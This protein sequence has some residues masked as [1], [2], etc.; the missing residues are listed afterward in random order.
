MERVIALPL[1]ML[2]GMTY[3]SSSSSNNGTN[4]LLLRAGRRTGLSSCV[5]SEFLGLSYALD[6]IT[7]ALPSREGKWGTGK[8]RNLPKVTQPITG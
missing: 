7:I 4:E 2:V 3:N 6:T 5:N 1:A 8:L